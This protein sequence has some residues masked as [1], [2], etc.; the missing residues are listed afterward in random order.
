LFGIVGVGR[1]IGTYQA[2]LPHLRIRYGLSHPRS[3]PNN[4]FVIAYEERWRMLTEVFSARSWRER[5][6]SVVGPPA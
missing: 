1:L 4:P 2:E 5:L 6:R 3:S